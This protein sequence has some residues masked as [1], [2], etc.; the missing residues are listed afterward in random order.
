MARRKSQTS[1]TGANMDSLLD[2]LTNV[3]G[4]LVIVLVAVQLSSQEAARRMEE[5]IAQIDPAEQERIKQEAEDSE[6]KLKEMKLALQAESDKDKIDPA[7]LLAMLQED[8]AA[9]EL[10]AKKDLLAAEAAEKA[11]EEKKLAAEK[12]RGSLMAQLAELE[13]KEKKFTVEKEDLLIKLEN[14]PT[15]NAPPPKEVRPPTPKDIPRKNDGNPL[16]SKK[17]ILISGG[18]VIPKV[19]PEVFKNQV[20]NY[21]NNIVSQSKIEAEE[22]RYITDEK[23]AI[24]LIEDFNKDPL[25]NEFFELKLVRNG[26]SINVEMIP[27][28][29]CGEDPEQAVKGIF[30]KIFGDKLLTRQWYLSYLVEPDSFE[31]YMAMRKV[32]D[33]YGYFAGWTII[34]PGNNRTQQFNVGYN[35]G[36]KPPPRTPG[37]PSARKPKA[38]KGVLD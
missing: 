8:I 27:K 36:A 17:E 20:K 24:K 30:N 35:V 23:K 18:K 6:A 31:T 28:E 34:N 26:A 7:K 14:M 16:L 22:G 38:V 29:N 11:A 33:R 13:A 37:P 4:I 15:L 2:A 25:Q 3:V 9:A 21:V 10:K 32:T 5:M 1:A 19:I 12:L